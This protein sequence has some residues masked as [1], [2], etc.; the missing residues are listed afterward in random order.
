[1]TLVYPL[2]A[3][4]DSCGALGS[5][6]AGKALGSVLS[7][8]SEAKTTEN[9]LFFYDVGPREAHATHPESAA[10]AQEFYE[11]GDPLQSL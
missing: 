1:M 5:S 3:R 10:S 9:L 11:I 7:A 2:R 6:W 8:P 4:G